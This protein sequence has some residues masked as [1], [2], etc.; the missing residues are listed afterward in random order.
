MNTIT[1]NEK[2]SSCKAILN[3]EMTN[4]IFNEN[5]ILTGGAPVPIAEPLGA[6]GYV[7][8]G[9]FISE[10]DGKTL[11]TDLT[12]NQLDVRISKNNGVFAQKSSGDGTVHDS[13]GMYNV[14]LGTADLIDGHIIIAIK[15]AGALPV[16]RKFQSIEYAPMPF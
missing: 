10:T 14:V 16:W 9:P 6:A 7:K 13:N 11:L 3:D 4:T 5:E 12:I 1:I 8:M 15:V 2:N